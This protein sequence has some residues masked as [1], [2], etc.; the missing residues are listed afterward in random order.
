MK[1]L[2]IPIDI[3]SRKLIEVQD[4]F[5]M[6]QVQDVMFQNIKPLLYLRNMLLSHIAIYLLYEVQSDF[7]LSMRKSFF[8]R[9]EIPWTISVKEGFIQSFYA[10]SAPTEVSVLSPKAARYK[11]LCCE[12]K[13]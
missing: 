9:P 10:S 2:L 7:I 1:V 5:W 6:L 3:H 12:L 8:F 4:V 11:N 13:G